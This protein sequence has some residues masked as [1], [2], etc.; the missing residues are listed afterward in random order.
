MQTDFVGTNAKEAGTLL[1]SAR[2][3]ADMSLR[4]FETWVAEYAKEQHSQRVGDVRASHNAIQRW[5]NGKTNQ[6]D[7]FTARVLSEAAF[8]LRTVVKDKPFPLTHKDQLLHLWI[9]STPEPN[10][11][12][13]QEQTTL[14]PDNFYG[15]P[16]TTE[17]V[18]VDEAPSRV[19]EL[20][21]VDETPSSVSEVTANDGNV[22]KASPE[23]RKIVIGAAIVVGL[24]LVAVIGALNLLK[25]ET[26]LERPVDQG[27]GIPEAKVVVADVADIFASP[28]R[29]AKIIGRLAKDAVIRVRC[30]IPVKGNDIDVW[31]AMATESGYVQDAALLTNTNNAV[32]PLCEGQRPITK[33]Q[34]DGFA[35][36]V[37][38][39]LKPYT[40]RIRK[41]PVLDPTSIVRE[42][43]SGT[44]VVATCFVRGEKV[45]ETSDIWYR[46]TDGHY[47]SEIYVYTGQLSP[48]VGLCSD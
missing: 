18:A 43:P 10:D 32:V 3:C 14:P 16:N 34:K 48:T 17:E 22:E 12:Q 27:V 5:E 30:H 6:F 35:V 20:T 19:S 2:E 8:H 44:S 42:V 39:P 23:K 15:S 31:Y 36:F 4:R 13:Q 21:A 41:L 38:V 25:D 37:R 40:A 33:I 26:K 47:V 29:D 46:L 9:P 1:R 28:R 11:D 7:P 24:F 45:L